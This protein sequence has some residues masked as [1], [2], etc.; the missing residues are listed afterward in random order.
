MSCDEVVKMVVGLV[1]GIKFVML[2]LVNDVGYIY[3]C[4]MIIQEIEF[5][6]DIWFIGVKD[7]EV[8]Y[9]VC[10]CFQVNVS[11]VDIGSN[12][13]VSVYGI[14]ELIEDCVKF[15]ELWSDMYNMYFEGGKEDLN[16]QFIKINVEGVEYWESGGKVWIFFVFVKNLIFG[17][18]VDVSELGKNDMVNF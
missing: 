9:D 3:L 11:Y 17:Q 16:V 5:D 2:V 1:K 18:C 15:D 8:V 4:F 7:S 10:S 13:Y 6:G 14:V 12:N